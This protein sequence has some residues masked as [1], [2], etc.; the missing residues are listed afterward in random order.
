MEDRRVVL[1]K[2]II[3]AEL[4]STNNFILVLGILKSFSKNI[5]LIVFCKGNIQTSV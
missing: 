3:L 4:E 5:Q 1:T 2:D